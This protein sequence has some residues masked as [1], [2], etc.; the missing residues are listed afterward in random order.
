MDALRKLSYCDQ[1]LIKLKFCTHKKNTHT[2]IL[3]TFKI[4]P[5]THS[6]SYS[7]R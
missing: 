6:K 7:T 1:K 4:E 3:V 5:E 2:V